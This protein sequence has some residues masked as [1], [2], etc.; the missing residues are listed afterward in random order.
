MLRCPAEAVPSWEDILVAKAQV[1]CACLL[2]DPL[3][4]SP[5]VRQYGEAVTIALP[6][7][8]PEPNDP[9]PC[10]LIKTPGR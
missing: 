7:K 4:K 8:A 1:Q 5:G 6:D 10:L 2:E 9:V 3:Y